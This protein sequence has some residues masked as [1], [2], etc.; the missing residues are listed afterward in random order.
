MAT[1][2]ALPARRSW[3]APQTLLSAAN[4]HQT[5][6]AKV[7][8]ALA[9]AASFPAPLDSGHLVRT[10]VLSARALPA[11]MQIPQ[12]N[13]TPRTRV[14]G[15]HQAAP[16]APVASERTARRE[17]S[18]FRVSLGSL[19]P[20]PGVLA[21][22]CALLGATAQDSSPRAALLVQHPGTAAAQARGTRRWPLHRALSLNPT[23]QCVLCHHNPVLNFPWQVPR[24][25]IFKRHWSQRCLAVHAVHCR[26]LLPWQC[27]RRRHF[28]HHLPTR[29]L[30]S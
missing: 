14:P 26:P 11:P 13:G 23:Q 25:H 28:A 24:R 15:L 7:C 9:S 16:P 18:A 1:A 10:L 30:L 2:P 4:A 5:A 3:V 6:G 12:S 22:T 8:L 19:R 29:Q 20:A 27:P 21:A 17:P